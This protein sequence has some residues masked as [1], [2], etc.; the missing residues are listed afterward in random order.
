ME[1]KSLRTNDDKLNTVLVAV[2]GKL[3]CRLAVLVPLKVTR[4]YL[5]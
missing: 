5:L 1:E 2:I 3:V 4:V